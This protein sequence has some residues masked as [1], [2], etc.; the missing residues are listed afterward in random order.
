VRRLCRDLMAAVAKYEVR[1]N[2]QVDLIKALFQVHPSVMLDELFSGDEES[3]KESV[4]LL[5]NLNRFDNNALDDIPDEI[6][7]DWCSRDPIIRYPIAAIGMALFRRSNDREPHAWTDLPRKLL[8]N[9]PE[10]RAIL[11]EIVYRL[12]PT[13]W[14]GSLAS[15]LE[16]RLKLLDDLPVGDVPDLQ[17]ALEEAKGVLRKQIEEQRRSETEEDKARSGRFK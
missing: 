14:S 17:A 2:D 1:A 13:S 9:A 7:L 8:E 16:S 11:N 12:R 10:P 4:R 5:N 6:I 15:N 3:R